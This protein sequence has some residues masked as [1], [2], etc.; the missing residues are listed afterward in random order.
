MT[1][2]VTR[3]IVRQNIADT[4]ATPRRRVVNRQPIKTVDQNEI[5][6]VAAL[7][8]VRDHDTE[9][10][11]LEAQVAAA[12]ARRDQT[13]ADAAALLHNLNLTSFI[14]PDSGNKIEIKETFSRRSIDTSVE[15]L[16][17]LMVTRYGAADGLKKFFETIK[18]IQENLK[19]YLTE[20]EI[21]GVSTITEGKKTGEKV[22]VTPL[23]K[24]KGKK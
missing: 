14:S 13:V 3:R 11:A 1:R 22:E 4:P 8:K 6:L 9:I 18:A 20:Q 16:H 19:T 7:M 15:K 5:D 10:E 24:K 17:K 21:K 23:A 12:N 2:T